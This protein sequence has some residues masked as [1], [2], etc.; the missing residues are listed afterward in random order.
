MLEDKQ[1]LMDEL[2]LDVYTFNSVLK[3]YR[4][5]VKSIYGQ[6][7]ETGAGSFDGE[8]IRTIAES[9][10]DTLQVVTNIWNAMN[11]D[12]AQGEML[13]R[14]VALNGIERRSATKSE[15]E[16]ELVGDV[17]TIIN[18]GV[19]KDSNGNNWMLPSVVEIDESPKTVVATAEEK[20]RI[21]ASAHTVNEIV[22]IT[23]GWQS[24]SNPEPATPG[25]NVEKDAQLRFRRFA[26]VARAAQNTV[27]SIFAEIGNIN[28][29]QKT[30]IYENDTSET[31]TNG[32]PSHSIEVVVQAPDTESIKENI[33]ESIRLQKSPGCGTHG[34][35]IQTVQYNGF[36]KDYKF[37][38]ANEKTVKV[39]VDISPLSNFRLAS[40]DTIKENIIEYIN[41]KQISE[42]LK[43]SSLFSPTLNADPR[44][45]KSPTF[46][47]DDIKIK[48]EGGSFGN[49]I[50]IGYRDVLFVEF[51]DIEVN[52]A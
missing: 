24:V 39:K 4:D 9:Q 19:V 33:G 40:V 14:L 37:S 47:V 16:L 45:Y 15:V 34:N 23:S 28:G 50:D 1:K 8:L 6:D 42:G 13:D 21:E 41:N 46:N 31:D 26:S 2:G 52:V 38:F 51:D 30:K 7:L 43:A 29:V 44:P 35:V 10:A 32:I 11:P 22:T 3:Y 49:S 18:N 5:L 17:G 25:T 48:L 12:F 27:D 36:E 20:G